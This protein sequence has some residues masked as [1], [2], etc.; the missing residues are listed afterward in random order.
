MNMV[1]DLVE[2]S[3][4]CWLVTHKPITIFRRESVELE[5]TPLIKVD[6]EGVKI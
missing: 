6:W 1:A 5:P 3:D 4:G 2:F